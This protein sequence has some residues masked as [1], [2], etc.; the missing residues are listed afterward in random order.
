MSGPT[1][2]W[3]ARESGLTADDVVKLANDE[4]FLQPEKEYIP[5]VPAK[6]Q[7]E[8]QR[9]HPYY[10][11]LRPWAHWYHCQMQDPN[12]ADRWKRIAANN[13]QKPSLLAGEYAVAALTTIFIAGYPPPASAKYEDYPIHDDEFRGVRP[14]SRIE[15]LAYLVQKVTRTDAR[16]ISELLEQAIQLRENCPD[17]TFGELRSLCSNVLDP[18]WTGKVSEDLVFIDRRVQLNEVKR[19]VGKLWKSLK[20]ETDAKNI[21]I[22]EDSLKSNL[23]V[24]D[25]REGWSDGRYH[26][27]KEKTLDEIAK[28]RGET[29][30]AVRDKYCAAFRTITGFDYSPERWWSVV[31]LMKVQK[32]AF[33]RISERRPRVSK[34]SGSVDPSYMSEVSHFA[35]VDPEGAKELQDIILDYLSLVEDGKSEHEIQET[36]QVDSSG[37]AILRSLAHSDRHAAE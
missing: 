32:S 1:E 19:D 35:A 16:R 21:R 29:V 12:N 8:L 31:A 2:E 5:L 37:L 6:M 25:L 36:L 26:A 15:V 18:A 24:W 28:M 4:K 14:A 3:A 27:D 20:G 7:W 34:S 13:V 33:G 23:E 30:L 17:V 10:Q 9:R 22:R 11:L